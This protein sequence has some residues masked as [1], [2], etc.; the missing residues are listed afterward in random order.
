MVWE[1]LLGDQC[2]SL[3]V[4]TPKPVRLLQ[5]SPIL[6]TDLRLGWVCD[7]RWLLAHGKADEPNGSLKQAFSR[8]FHALGLLPAV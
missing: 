2:F 4:T 8:A 6:S 1:P 7:R 5:T 3:P